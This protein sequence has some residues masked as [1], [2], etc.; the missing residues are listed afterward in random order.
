MVYA[1]EDC[2]SGAQVA[3]KLLHAEMVGTSGRK[4]FLQEIE[5]ARRLAHPGI[6]PVLDSGE[7]DGSLYLVMPVV[8]GESLHA[9]LRR[10]R[11]LPVP[12]ALRIA[13][14]VA[15]A[16]AYAH[17]AG[18]VHRDIK[19]ANILLG[20]HRALVADFGIARALT[21]SATA[22]S[23]SSSG[24]QVGT[25]A[26]MSP[27]QASGDRELDGRADLYSLGCVLYEMLGGGP[28]FSGPTAQSMVARHAIDPVP[29]LRTVRPSVPASL[30]ELV[31]R[32]LA[33]SPADRFT[34]TREFA[35]ALEQVARDPLVSVAGTGRRGRRRMMMGVAAT[36]VAAS[37]MFGVR[38]MASAA[39]ASRLAEADTI[40]LVILPVEKAAGIANTAGLDEA[41]RRAF[42]RWKGLIVVDPTAILERL[43]PGAMPSASRARDVA[44]EQRA[45]RYVRASVTTAAGVP[46]L[47]ITIHDAKSPE[48]ALAE[49]DGRLVE[50]GAAR[51]SMLAFLADRVL[52][53]SDVPATLRTGSGGTVSLPARQAYVSGLIAFDAW[54]LARSD[55]QFSLALTFDPEFAQASLGIALARHWTNQRPPLWSAAA[56]AANSGRARLTSR[57]R[58]EADALLEVVA[59]RLPEACAR[60]DAL[61]RAESLDFTAWYGAANCLARDNAVEADRHSASGWRFRTSYRAALA[62]YR[63]AFELHPAVLRALRDNGFEPVRR[64]LKTSVGDMRSGAMSGTPSRRFAAYATL[65]ADT[66]AFIPFPAEVFAASDPRLLATIPSTVGAAI[67]RQRELFRDLVSSWSS[68]APASV[69]ARE[70]LSWALLLLGERSAVDTLV[71]ARSLAR[72]EADSLRLMATEA[73]MRAQLSI[74][75]DR[76]GVRLAKLIADSVLGHRAVSTLGRRERAGLAALTGRAELAA[77]LAAAEATTASTGVP[78]LLAP[79]A[80]ALRVYAALGGPADSLR[81]LD[82]RLDS[83]IESAVS[84]SERPGLR[85]RAL[86]RAASLAFGVVTLRALPELAAGGDYLLEAQAAWLRG[87]SAAVRA[88]LGRIRSSRTPFS[89]ADL[90]LDALVPEA[91]L[92]LAMG[93]AEG[94]RRWLDP[95]LQLLRVRATSVDPIHAGSLVRVLRLREQIAL[96][97]ADDAGAAR[98]RAVAA[99]LLA[100]ADQF[101]RSP[102]PARRSP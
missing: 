43:E 102:V 99:I 46:H 1:A 8:E 69:E 88:A 85:Q 25:A 41:L 78:L 38:A 33:K 3:I 21:R 40:R 22:D 91:T 49:V 87:D 26:Y 57:E 63:R 20:P 64:L 11:Q 93:D 84:A 17:A 98:W 7:A 77:H 90:T 89:P 19:P 50:P 92:L 94:A 101:L 4:R 86:G 75:D 27:E 32:A 68:A 58:A 6:V 37:G 97:L 55:S 39:E 65:V 71:S 48:T 12:E 45:R 34:D 13:R 96:A 23:I 60:W 5:F 18:I 16:L 76:A 56:N 82:A 51:D 14:E 95:T 30:E 80:G 47:R 10:E 100:D 61:A 2:A 59:G 36:A 52:V 73:W 66:L 72:T 81:A 29:P 9:R 15:E 67:R 83:L 35:V 31:Y 24:V 53:R 70:A 28:P 74:P 62:R 44:L 42:V 79:I 54:D